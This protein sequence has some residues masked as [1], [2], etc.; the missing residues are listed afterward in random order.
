M[1][2]HFF[3]LFLSTLLLSVNAQTTGDFGYWDLRGNTGTNTRMNFIGTSDNQPI[4]F[5]TWNTERMRLLTDRS[6]FG[7]GIPTP[8]ATLHLHYQLDAGD[9]PSQKLLQLTTPTCTTGFSIIYNRDTKDI[10]FRQQESAKFF[11]EGPGG[12]LAIAQDGNVG[13]GTDAPKQKLHIDEGNLLITCSL[14]DDPDATVGALLFGKVVDNIY[15]YGQWGIEYQNQPTFGVNGLNFRLYDGI[16]GL[17]GNQSILFLSQ[18]GVGVGTKNPQAK[19]DV[20][21]LFKAKSAGID[22]TLT[23]NKLTAN[24]ATIN[25][26][27]TAK[28]ANI[29]SKLGIGTTAPITNMQIGNLW[30]FQNET[31]FNSM[32]RNTYFNGLGDDRIQ[33]GAASKI[34]FKSTGDILLQTTTSDA[35]GTPLR[36]NTVTIANNGY[37]GIGTTAAPKAMLDVN[38]DTQISGML[39]A[40]EIKV[41]LAP[42]WPDYVFSKDY[43]L[44]PLQELEQFVNKNQHLPNVPTAT[45][46]AENGVNVGEMNAILLQKLEEMT[47]YI[48]QQNKKLTDLQN[49]IDEL[50]SSKP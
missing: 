31:S 34:T 26:L 38:G 46:V 41:Q 39:C 23:A 45:S 14:S 15:P 13:L 42:C 25:G 24:D 27:L 16:I 19:L 4:I 29:T 32:G 44:M 10:Y 36:W 8:Q 30:T 9:P 28:S 50:K 48:L 6:F 37:V 49:Q 18:N 40:K 33:S 20:K 3:I 21:G 7:I 17:S 22:S 1:K 12:G 43:N 35:A 2:K 11:L 5:K 47:L